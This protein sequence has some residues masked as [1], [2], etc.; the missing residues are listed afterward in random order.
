LLTMTMTANPPTYNQAGQTITFTYAIKN[1]GTSTLG[2]AQFTVSGSLFGNTPANCGA[3]NTT[4]APNETVTC[5]ATY[6]ITDTDMTVDS[7]TNNATAS[8]GGATPSQT[9]SA[10]I[11]K[12]VALLSLTTSANPITYNQAGQTITYTYVIRNSGNITL[13]PAQFTVSD[14]LFGNSNLNCSAADTTLTPGAT[15]SCTAVYTISEENLNF[16][17]LTNIATASGGGAGPSQPASTIIN[18][19]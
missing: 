17:T 1:S 7:I 11:S 10:T 19:Q 12:S 4:L 3:A 15:V 16:D 14:N 18:K 9:T 8:G 5:S 13:G 6:T 2:L